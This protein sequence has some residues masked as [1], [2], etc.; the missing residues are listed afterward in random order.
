M[1]YFLKLSIALIFLGISCG[2][3]NENHPKIMLGIDLLESRNFDILQG[4]R[5]GLLTHQ[6]GVNGKG[7]ST[8]EVLHKA[9]NVNLVALYSPEHG[10]DGKAIA[11]EAVSDRVEPKTGLPAYSVFGATR[12]P[13]KEMLD[14]IDVMVIDLQDVGVR[15]YT[16]ISC[17]EYVMEA[18]F[19]NNKAVVVLDRPNPLG[20]LKVEGPPM[21][22][23]WIGYVGAYKVPLVHGMTIGELAFLAKEACGYLGEKGELTVIPMK[24]WQRNMIWEDTGLRWVP[25]SP[26]IPTPEAVKGYPLTGLGCEY[27]LFKHGLQTSIH[28]FRLITYPGKKAQEVRDALKAKNISGLDFKVITY[29]DLKDNNAFKEGVFVKITDWKKAKLTELPF[30]MMQLACEWSEAN[31]YSKLD[32]NTMVLFNKHVGSTEWWLDLS[33]KGKKVDVKKF[34]KRWA[35][36]SE[37]FN[38]WRQKYLLYK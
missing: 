26:N 12:R 23:Q 28:P 25:T 4:K 29:K 6:A 38:E 34:L 35:I 7:K 9:P 18:C 8:I 1:N 14:P 31:P 3:S 21:D 11:N 22:I 20:G 17:M 15:C 32:I 16:Y 2:F 19:E 24:G 13:T 5:V 27:N 30:Y 37:R 10:I 36:Q 33:S